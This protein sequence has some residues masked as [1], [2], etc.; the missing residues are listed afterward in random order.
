MRTPALPVLHGGP[1]PQSICGPV[2]CRHAA[3][4]EEKEKDVAAYKAQVERVEAELKLLRQELAEEAHRRAHSEALVASQRH[5]INFLE[6]ALAHQRDAVDTIFPPDLREIAGLPPTDPDLG[7][8]GQVQGMKKSSAALKQDTKVAQKALK[9]VPKQ[10]VEDAPQEEEPQPQK[11]NDAVQRRKSQNAAESNARQPAP[12]GGIPL[13]TQKSI[14]P[15][16]GGGLSPAPGGGVPVGPKKHIAPQIGGG[17]GPA[18]GGGYASDTGTSIAP[19]PS[20]KF[21]GAF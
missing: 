15:R 4:L 2:K 13:Q 3:M 12:G 18:A 11:V 20:K 16:V 14:S 9:T 17:T 8:H 21:Q 7:L 6:E 10:E 1:V 5:T 19:A